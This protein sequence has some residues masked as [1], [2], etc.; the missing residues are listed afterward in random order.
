MPFSTSLQIEMTVGKRRVATDDR[1]LPRAR[2]PLAVPSRGPYGFDRMAQ[3]PSLKAQRLL[4]IL[5][6]EPLGYSVVRQSGSHRQLRA[7]GRPPLTFAFHDS[8]TIPG[9]MVRK[10]LVHDV[11]LDEDE[12]R[13]IV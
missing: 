2:L 12:A 13:R 5:R 8:A 4:S 7:E 11:G 10:I 6:A 1:G 3:F 9:G